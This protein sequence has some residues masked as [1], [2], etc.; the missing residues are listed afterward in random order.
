MRVADLLEQ[1]DELPQAGGRDMAELPGV[2]A[3]DRFV[4]HLEQFQPPLRQSHLDDA[5][6][7]CRPVATDQL[8]SSSLSTSG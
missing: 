3:A 8:R 6:V 7:V 1:R 4:E 2:T 5:A